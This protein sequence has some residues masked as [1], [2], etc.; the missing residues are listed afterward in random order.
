MAMN[1]LDGTRKP[2][3]Y[4]SLDDCS[5]A[6][7]LEDGTGG[8]IPDNAKVALIQAEG[9]DARWRDDGTAP[10]VDDTNGGHLLA[11][12]DSFW[13]IGDLETIEFIEAV[14]TATVDVSVS[15]YK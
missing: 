11:D 2:L 13:Y 8:A 10:T 7:G 6:K 15:F 9:A 1:I 3:G 14:G 12:G 5:A 4:T